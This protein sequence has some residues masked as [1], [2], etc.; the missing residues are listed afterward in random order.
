MKPATNKTRSI[1]P[2]RPSSKRKADAMPAFTVGALNAPPNSSD[3][4]KK[5]AKAE[6]KQL[7][8]LLKKQRKERLSAVMATA[9]AFPMIDLIEE[10]IKS[11]IPKEVI[12]RIESAQTKKHITGMNY[13]YKKPMKSA[14]YAA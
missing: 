10:R 2:K 7:K 13:P 3:E 1:R 4:A 9:S 12:K 11:H 6:K 14:E 5:L 8:K